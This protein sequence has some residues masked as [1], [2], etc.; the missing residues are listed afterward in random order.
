[1]PTSP[2]TICPAPG[3]NRLVESG[4]GRCPE[5]KPKQ[6]QGTSKNRSGDPFYSSQ[7]WM[8]VRDARRRNS[9]LCQECEKE[10]R[11]TPMHAVDHKKPRVDYPELAL[12]YDN[13]QSLCETHHNRKTARERRERQSQCT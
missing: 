10:G 11:V 7:A 9:P 5:C 6:Y 4:I 3:C 2:K 8:R 12:D 13:T 1:M